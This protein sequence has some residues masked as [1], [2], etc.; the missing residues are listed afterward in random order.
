MVLINGSVT[1]FD[2]LNDWCL[3]MRLLK[4]THEKPKLQNAA[5]RGKK[6]KQK[7]KIVFFLLKEKGFFFSITVLKI[8]LKPSLVPASEFAAH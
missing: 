2:K 5:F 4:Q 8:Q 3:L 6:E 1:F 7:D